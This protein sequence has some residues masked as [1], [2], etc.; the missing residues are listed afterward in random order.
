MTCDKEILTLIETIYDGV[1]ADDGLSKFIAEFARLFPALEASIIGHRHDGH[2][3]TIFATN[4]ANDTIKPY[5]ETH[6]RNDPFLPVF[7]KLPMAPQITWHHDII[8]SNA[9][10]HISTHTD[11][12]DWFATTL[13]RNSDCFIIFTVHFTRP[14]RPNAHRAAKILAIITPH[15][16]RALKMQRQSEQRNA[17]QLAYRHSLNQLKTAILCINTQGEIKFANNLAEQLLRDG[18]ALTADHTNRLV[19]KNS[20]DN[21]QIYTLLDPSNTLHNSSVAKLSPT[22]FLPLALPSENPLIA[23]LTPIS[24]PAGFFG[25]DPQFLIFL[26]NSKSTSTSQIDIIALAFNL[27]NAEARLAQAVIQGSSAKQYASARGLSYNTVRN[28]SQSLLAKT[29]TNRQA[30]MVKTLLNVVGVMNFH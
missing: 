1:I 19:F 17:R 23:Y 25:T 15:L 20:A 2:A 14:H 6:W 10:P 9:S 18:T 21:A 13:Y 4:L 16:Q 12:T 29:S 27:T 28:Q 8:A 7:A 30:E 26:I 24:P 22:R 3:P 11:L 5:L